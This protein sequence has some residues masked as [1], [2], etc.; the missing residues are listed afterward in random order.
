MTSLFLT[1]LYRKTDGRYYD[2]IEVSMI[3]I[4]VG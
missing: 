2:L 4:V 3:M 1:A